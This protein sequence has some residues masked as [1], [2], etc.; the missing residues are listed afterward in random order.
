MSWPA[1]MNLPTR[2]LGRRVL[3]YDSIPSTNDIALQHPVGAA[4]LADEQTAGRGQLGRTWHSPPRSSVLLSVTFD[5]PPE[6]RRPVILTAWAVVA[7]AEVVRHFTGELPRIKW[8]NDVLLSDKKIAGILIEQKSVVVAGIGLNVSQTAEQFQ[9]AKLPVA[10]SLASLSGRSFN[11]DEIARQLILHLDAEYDSLLHGR[12]ADLESRWV[13]C[14][15][16]VGHDVVAEMRDDTTVVGALRDLTFD[17]VT[18]DTPVAPA[19]FAPESIRR[20]H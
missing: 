15:G 9:I 2:H 19:S 3:V 12:L 4:I 11:R 16:L 1:A 13:D 18:I 5:P 17:R 10:A 14:L 8:P 20:F 6:L 7:V